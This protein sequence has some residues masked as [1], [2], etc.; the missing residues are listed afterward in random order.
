MTPLSTSRESVDSRRDSIA[1][2]IS[3]LDS[4]LEGA[5]ACARLVATGPAA[6]EPL[7]EFLLD[8]RPRSVPDPRV[9]AVRALSGLGADDVLLEFLR[10][11]TASDDAILRFAEETV[12]NAAAQ[13]LADSPLPGVDDVLVATASAEHLPA[14]LTAIATREPNY[15][16]PILIRALEDDFARDAASEGL[17]R[18][19]VAAREAL[20]R[21]A[22]D[23]GNGSEGSLRR[24]RTAV[25][26]LGQLDVDQ[27]TWGR[28][29][30]VLAET[31]AALVCTVARVGTSAGADPVRI[32]RRLLEILPN[33]GW[34]WLSTV[35]D[36]VVECAMRGGE[37]CKV[38]MSIDPERPLRPG[39]LLAWRRICRRIAT[40]AS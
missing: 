9:W 36:M 3:Q 22:L 34:D 2:L 40:E 15:A 38:L 32:V 26:L 6:V 19:G 37:T 25:D 20:I 16:L 23:R 28:L 17:R 13:A 35:E 30:P 7:R 21:T 1:Q 12:R 11:P 24:R 5:E 33:V 29:Q 10:R 31:D 39:V 27:S 4:L 18:S 14:A 8:G